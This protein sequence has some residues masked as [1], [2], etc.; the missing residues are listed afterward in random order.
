MGGVNSPPYIE[1]VITMSFTI[2]F[3]Y[4]TGTFVVVDDINI[5]CSDNPEALIG[6]F[7]SIVCYQCVD[8][9]DNEMIVMVSGY[10]D[11]WCGE[12]LLSKIRLASDS[13]IQ[14]YKNYLGIKE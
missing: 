10:K 3:P 11:A 1:R 7:G 8:E 2:T 13:E 5:D 12:Y 14:S 9:E 4:N 6:H